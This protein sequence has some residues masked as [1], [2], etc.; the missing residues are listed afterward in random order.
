MTQK[1][2]LFNTFFPLGV[3]AVGG[4]QMAAMWQHGRGRCLTPRHTHCAER[5]AS[6]IPCRHNVVAAF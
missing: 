4:P 6:Y 1:E 5:Y 2:S 3:A